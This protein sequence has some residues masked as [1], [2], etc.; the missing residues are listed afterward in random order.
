MLGAAIAAPALPMV[1]PAPVAA[2]Y[3]RYMYGLAVFHARTRAHVSVRGLALGLRVSQAQAT[4]MIAEM[5]SGGLV[6]SVGVGN[7]RA[8]SNILRPDAWGLSKAARVQRS[9]IRKA[10]HAA[11]TVEPGVSP[12]M[13]H[14]HQMCRKAGFTV[15]GLC[16]PCARKSQAEFGRISYATS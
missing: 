16:T 9:T 8:V 10:K 7:V 4:A 3:S 14:L 12:L 13:A 1:A 11:N 5:S 6:T 2:T 15:H